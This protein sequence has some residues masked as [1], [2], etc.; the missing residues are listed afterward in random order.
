MKHN[1][2]HSNNL[3][4]RFLDHYHH[5]EQQQPQQ[6][7]QQQ[8]QQKDLK[9]APLDADQEKILASFGVLVRARFGDGWKRRY[10]VSFLHD[11]DWDMTQALA[12]MEDCQDANY[13]LLAAPPSSCS[14]CGGLLG[15]ENDQGTSCYLDALL[16]AMYIG[17]TSFDPML[18]GDPF[19]P[20]LSPTPVSPSTPL[21]QQQQQQRYRHRH[22]RFFSKYHHHHRRRH[23][24]LTPFRT[25]T[26]PPPSPPPLPPSSRT[27][28]TRQR[29]LDDLHIKTNPS[30]LINNNSS[31][32]SDSNDDDLALQQKHYLQR[33]L[34]LFVNK[35]RKGQLVK[36]SNV[37]QV[38]RALMQNGW[39]GPDP[40]T[41]Q[42][43]QEDVSEL[44]LFLTS[45][46]DS[47]YLPFQ[48]RLFHGANKDM[49]DDRIMTDRLLPLSL[50]P[51]DDEQQEPIRLETILVDQ[52][53]NSVVSGVKRKVDLEEQAPEETEQ[54]PI[55]RSWNSS[56]STG[57]MD[58]TDKGILEIITTPTKQSADPMK[59]S[60]S[61]SPPIS[62]GTPQRRE[63][64]VDA[65]QA[66]EL[67]PFY[68]SSSS[69]GNSND[70][71]DYYPDTH[72]V[73]PLVL[74]RYK[75]NNNG[76]AYVKDTRPVLVPPIIPFHQFVNQNTD[77]AVCSQ[78]NVKMD[79]VMSLKS[80]VAHQ[81]SSPYSGHYVAYTK[82]LSAVPDHSVWLKFDDLNSQER[83][84]YDM[85]E[86]QVLDQ[87]AEH[88]YLFFYELNRL[89]S[90][91]LQ[92]SFERMMDQQN[93]NNNTSGSD[94][95]QSDKDDVDTAAVEEEVE[96]E[97]DITTKQ[98]QQEHESS[99]DKMVKLVEQKEVDNDANK[100][101]PPTTISSSVDKKG[102][103]SVQEPE[104]W[105]ETVASSSSDATTTTTTTTTAAAK[106]AVNPTSS[107]DKCLMM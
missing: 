26:P 41:Q 27:V 42:W 18:L 86:A 29:T 60:S 59:K 54:Q 12:D 30:I 63:T 14:P 46:F 100:E 87:V 68:S 90:T 89:C 75:T 57:S 45:I 72:L 11:A 36:T 101:T 3:W 73:L 74:K 22:H 78:C 2:R 4:H 53:Y 81:G 33:T 84:T 35:L 58:S 79:Y 61:S 93:E 49:D 66:M 9:P 7:E 103:L 40:E 99:H 70:N 62:R 96:Q 50:P 25:S 10:L 56:S 51:P 24:L 80:I 13:G 98:H 34:R 67:L 106:P 6:H 105:V 47:P 107:S 97:E 16:F 8:P 28:D 32:S 102:A 104:D 94:D 44:F 88:G 65:W 85:S 31:S 95:S 1:K 39:Y 64:E 37:A 69:N 17:L 71:L 55:A 43:Q 21:E 91:C 52:F 92:Q 77:N 82:L 19:E 5:D 76:N 20:A 83:V 38:R 48:L 23:R 15:C